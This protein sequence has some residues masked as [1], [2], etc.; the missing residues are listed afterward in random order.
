VGFIVAII[1]GGVIGWLA[2]VIMKANAQMGLIANSV[3][4]V[5]G[6]ASGA[7]RRRPQPRRSR[8]PWQDCLVWSGGLIAQRIT[9]WGSSG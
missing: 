4:G 9:Q 2:S 5:V 3:V 6:P 1:L 7:G 8:L